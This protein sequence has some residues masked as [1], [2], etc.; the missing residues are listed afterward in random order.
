MRNLSLIFV[1]TSF[2][3]SCNAKKKATIITVEDNYIETEYQFEN[4]SSNDSLFTSIYK[5]ACF[6]KCPV[7]SMKIYND[8][9]VIYVGKKNVNKI[10]TYKNKLEKE[11]LLLFIDKANEIKYM[12]LED[13][14]D[15]KNITDL[16][17]TKTSIV[18]DK[19]RKS[20]ERR[21]G[22]PKEILAFEQLFENLL[23]DDNWVKTESSKKR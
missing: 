13:S 16:P 3:I 1:L 20:I 2:L 17:S 14:Y 7:Y 18:I 9:S 23:T 8:G 15:N 11:K 4:I 21:F 19:K 12:E 6:G 5:S 10:G 22:Y